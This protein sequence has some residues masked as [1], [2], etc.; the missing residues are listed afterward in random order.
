MRQ[1][2]DPHDVLAGDV[3]IEAVALGHFGAGL[4]VDRRRIHAQQRVQDVTWQ[5]ADRTKDHNRDGHQ[6]GHRE[7]DA[8]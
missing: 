6:R 3:L 2:I 8:A 7:E 4:G 5:E 1:V